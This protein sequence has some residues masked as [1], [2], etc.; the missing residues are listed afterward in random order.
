[1]VPKVGNIVSGEKP[2]L[3]VQLRSTLYSSLTL[4]G[5]IFLDDCL[6][7]FRDDRWYQFGIHLLYNSFCCIL[8][9]KYVL[10]DRGSSKTI[11]LLSVQNQLQQILGKC[12]IVSTSMGCAWEGLTQGHSCTEG[13]VGVCTE[14]SIVDIY[15]V[16]RKVTFPPKSC[17]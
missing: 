14:L 7:F 2:S 11:W 5:I 9:L 13:R 8:T 3:Q 12:S 17:T 1:M 4:K 6:F 16:I 10:S 15:K